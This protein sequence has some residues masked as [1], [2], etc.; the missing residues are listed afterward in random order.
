MTNINDASTTPPI[1]DPAPFVSP[2]E[3]PMPTFTY[4][5]G[6]AGSGKTFLTKE[7]AAREKVLL[8]ASTGIAA[9]NL[10]GQTINSTLGYF[11]TKSLQDAYTNGFLTGKLG[12]LWR[13]GI[14]RIVLDESSMVDADQLTYLV[15][16]IE[17]VNGRGYV[18]DSRWEDDLTPPEMGLTLVGDFAQLSPV[19]AEYAFT[20]PEWYR[21]ADATVTLTE[22]RRQADPDFI[23]ALRK[24]R[25]GD[26]KAA[27]EYFASRLHDHTDDHFDGPTILAR[28][29]AVDR[30]NRLRMDQLTGQ[31]IHFA[32]SRWGKQ[33]S[34]WGNPEKPPQTWGIPQT[35]E[36]KEGAKIMVLANKKD[37]ETKRLIYV[38]GDIGTL[39]SAEGHLAQ[40]RLTRTGEV[41]EVEYVERQVK[42][43]CDSARKK[44][45]RDLGQQD[46]IDGKWEIL[47][48]I[49]Y[50]PLRLAYASTVH[51]AQGL[52]LDRVQVNIRDPFYKTPGM[53]YVALSRARTAEGLRLVGS[54]AAFIERCVSDPRLKEW[55]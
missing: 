8:T 52:S 4:L 54:P 11:D 47:G 55:L 45:L 34:E 10:G 7:W 14:K 15:R 42:I 13:A 39:E 43:P 49:S 22:I 18:L 31:A 36:L 1:L 20:S 51:K 32:S 19:K 48:S 29:E 33:R 3:S 24:A 38:N 12:R 5:C 9:I 46:K 17:E 2:W 44:E 50:M 16:A 27:L 35:L 23:H 53:V 30:L 37:P 25:L 28:N 26:G 6:T 41:V 40:V 21:F